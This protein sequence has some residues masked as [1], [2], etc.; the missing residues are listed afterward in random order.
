MNKK[1]NFTINLKRCFI[2]NI[3]IFTI[4]M[5]DILLVHYKLDGQNVGIGTSNPHP[6]ARLEVNDNTRGLLIPR[7]TTAERDAIANPANSLL[8]FNTTTQCF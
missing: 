8:I 6:S 4:I 7:M 3:V 1:I 5:V 2:K